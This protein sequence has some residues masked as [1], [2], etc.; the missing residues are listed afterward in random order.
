MDQP[1]QH[2]I[3]RPASLQGRGLF[4]GQPVEVTFRPA[5]ANHGVVFVRTD[6]G[7]KQVPASIQH[8][9]KR[10]RRTALKRD[11]A[12]IH[13]CEHVLSA[14]AGLRIDNLVIEINAPELPA[15]D[16]SAQPFVETLGEAGLVEIDAPRQCIVVKEP[17]T[18]KLDDAVIA[19]LPCEE[20]E[21]QVLYELDYGEDRRLGRQVRHFDFRNGDYQHEIAP[22]RTYCTEEEA[23][24]L[25]ARGMA[26][27]LSAKDILVIGEHGPLEGNAFR[28]T[29][30]PVRHKVLDLIGDL[31]LVGA[32]IRGRIIAHKSGHPLNHLLAKALIRQ[33][34]AHRRARLASRTV[35]VDARK[36]MRMLPHRF[37]MLLVDRVVEIDEDRRAVGVKNVTINEPYFQG[38]YPTAP[39]MPGVL[40][41]EAMA[42]LSGVLIGQSLEHTGKL[43]VL[44]SLDRV[45]L[46]KPVTPGDTL[47][48]EAETVRVRSR[49]AHMRCRAYVAQDLAAEAEVKFMLVDDEQE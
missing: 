25:R 17:V 48:L 27:H 7:G 31:Y 38:H 2:T 49:I 13:T 19:A 15:F 4:G 37:P 35:A 3:D 43:A 18:V 42:Q 29:D 32:P 14:L 41:V 10:P 39:I 11:D 40:V 26:T 28:F 22:A 9:V 8:V 44:L 24:E 36:L 23:N 6:L 47:I 1:R 33:H 34:E 45:K 20:Q 46:R 12:E 16:G 21:M 5:P 30:E